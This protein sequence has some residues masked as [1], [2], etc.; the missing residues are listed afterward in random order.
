MHKTFSQN[1]YCRVHFCLFWVL[2]FINFQVLAQSNCE[3]NFYNI[4]S[5][6]TSSALDVNSI[7]SDN[8][9]MWF[10]S[11][12]GLFRFDGYELF[13]YSP[14]A[15]ENNTA[16]QS[17]RVS[18][19]VT[20]HN[21][22]LWIGT[23]RNGLYVKKITE[24]CLT[25]FV[26]EG[27]F[28]NLN[29]VSIPSICTDDSQKIW[30]ISPANQ[31]YFIEPQTNKTSKVQLPQ[32]KSL[33]QKIFFNNFDHNIWVLTDSEKI[34]KVN[35]DNFQVSTAPDLPYDASKENNLVNSTKWAGT[36]AYGTVWASV[37]QKGLFCLANKGNAWQNVPAFQGAEIRKMMLGADNRIYCGVHKKG[38][39]VIDPK[40]LRY[41]YY[42]SRFSEKEKLNTF[43]FND[44]YLDRNENLWIGSA[45]NGI[46]VKYREKVSCEYLSSQVLLPQ[47]DAFFPIICVAKSNEPGKFWLGMDGKGLMKFDLAQRAF[48]P[49]GIGESGSKTVKT[50]FTDSK[51]NLWLGYWHDGLL[52]Y[53]PNTHQTT[54]YNSRSNGPYQL[55]GLSIWDIVEDQSAQLWVSCLG[56]GLV[57]FS[58]DGTQRKVFFQKDPNGTPY[59]AIDLLC[60]SNGTIWVAFEDHGIAILPRGSENFQWLDINATGLN[61]SNVFN[62]FEDSKGQIWVGTVNAGL[63]LWKD[64]KFV[65][66]TEADGLS[67]NHVQSIVED[68]KGLI[69]VQSIKNATA[70]SIDE[71]KIV[72]KFKAVSP[73]LNAFNYNS[74]YCTEDNHILIGGSHYLFIADSLININQ[75][76]GTMPVF[77]KINTHLGTENEAETCSFLAAAYSQGQ[78]EIK[79]G[80]QNLIIDFSCTDLSAASIAEYQYWLENYNNDWVSIPPGERRVVF[81]DLPSGKYK[82]RARCRA[83]TADWSQEITLNVHIN[84]PFW[85]SGWLL[86]LLIFSSCMLLFLI[87]WQKRRNRLIQLEQQQLL[88]E[89]EQLSQEIGSKNNDL[90]A[91]TAEMAQQNERLLDIKEMLE[92]LKK[93]SDTQSSAQLR[94]ISKVLHTTLNRNEEWN[95]FMLYFDASNQ[96][97]TRQLYKVFPNI[98]KSELLIAI[99]VRLGIQTKDIAQMLNITVMGVN[100]SKY[101]LK[102]RLNLGEEQD[103]KLFLMNFGEDA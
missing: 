59:K 65:S 96:N 44:L 93:S 82:L 63:R 69:W 11:N 90:L 98:T 32:S 4:T 54:L 100:K 46:E 13:L 68:K 29:E 3:S 91:R 16:P 85:E 58:A 9:F 92:A 83:N 36:D 19:L 101:R 47:S 77:A 28:S 24:T 67:S 33:P 56:E 49:N 40:T 14:C 95:A 34:W 41:N 38:I 61:T 27:E 6:T 86:P 8:A 37:F 74:A 52:C 15:P 79:S 103:L 88:Q 102:K 23:V 78:I 81:R 42:Q 99:M 7:S 45:G 60:D 39:Y 89:K 48:L 97:F 17:L 10:G 76:A 75:Q 70:L 25:K 1:L 35:S 66:F 62:V 73:D 87:L 22:T 53:S 84:L 71:N 20:D 2:I 43:V 26:F 57:R 12:T 80:D 21:N 51:K 55:E 72:Q 50:I 64:G 31:L 5:G 30:F 94:Q 18:A